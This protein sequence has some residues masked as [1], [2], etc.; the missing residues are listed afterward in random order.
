VTPHDSPS[1]CGRGLEGGGPA[2]ESSNVGVKL[3]PPPPPNPLP[4]GEGESKST[5][6]RRRLRD[7]IFANPRFQRWA[8]SFPLTRGIA[9]RR[10]SGL[11][12]LCAGFVYSQVLLACVR[13]R[14][15]DIL[16]EGPQPLD[17]LAARLSLPVDSASR[18]L[19]AAVALRLAETLR[20][21]RFAL[22]VLGT[23]LVGNPSVAALVEHNALLYADLRDPV[24]LLRHEQPETE[25][26]K[27][28]PYAGHNPAPDAIAIYST[29]MAESQPLVAADVLETYDLAR[30]R[31]LLDLGG[32]DGSFLLAA[33]AAAPSLRLILFDL[34]AVAERAR[35]R[36]GAAGLTG[37]AQAIGGDLRSGVLPPGADLISLVRVIH[38]HDDKSAMAILRAAREALPPD[39][40]LLLA[41][42]MAGTPGAETVGA[43]FHF[44]LLAMGSGRPRRPEELSEMLQKAGFAWVRLLPTRRPMLVRVL[45][46]DCR[47]PGS[48]PIPRRAGEET[49]AGQIPRPPVI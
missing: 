9:R 41:E 20:D 36:F 3:Q 18:L 42:P 22:G 35:A 39:G 30:H 40:T 32:G 25:L 14:L 27:L 48:L 1:P 6:P 43:Y 37:R 17:R 12:D 31:C 23:A 49:A 19:E 45:V 5:Q 10:A 4:Q 38:D 46:A 34:P 24:A 28:W 29:L 33:A 2:S 13:L 8:A 15:C 16:M 11:F 26:G 47:G 7:R 21:G 44:Y